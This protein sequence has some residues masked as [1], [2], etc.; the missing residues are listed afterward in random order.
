MSGRLSVRFPVQQPH[1][2]SDRTRELLKF[3]C[4]GSD[5]GG[6]NRRPLKVIFSLKTAA[7][8]GRKVFDVRIC[9]C[10]RRDKVSY[11]LLRTVLYT[12]TVL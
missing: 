12:C 3:M 5:V 7:V 4:L 6:I 2:G 1:E 8:L 10:P 11:N 9:S